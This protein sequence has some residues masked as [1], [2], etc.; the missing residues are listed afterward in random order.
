[1][2]RTFS[3]ASA[4]A[5]CTLAMFALGASERA[6]AQSAAPAQPQGI[7]PLA[8]AFGS[9]GAASGEGDSIGT[10]HGGGGGE[11]VFGDAV[12]VGAEI[13]YVGPFEEL[14]DGL[15]V[16]SVNGSYHFLS[17]Q[18]RKLRPFVTGGY[19]LVFRDGHANLWNIGGG[20][21]YW[22]NQRVAIRVEFRDH[23]W[24]AEELH[25]WGARIGVAF[26]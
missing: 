10:L 16:L 18:S 14:R 20:V 3:P 24:S 21:H 19:T 7:Y 22:L 15:G 4:V 5:V 26:R 17:G 11:S 23:V 12:G 9:V 25:A 13:G 2:K 8:Y 1:M 6:R